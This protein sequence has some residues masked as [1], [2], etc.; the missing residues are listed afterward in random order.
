[1]SNY[2]PLA[3]SARLE[4]DP[5]L[6]TLFEILRGYG[7]VPAAKWLKGQQ[8]CSLTFAEMTRRSD[9]YAACLCSLAPESGWMALAVDTCVE[10]PGI[11]WGMI[12][13][14]HN[15][16]LLDAAA[17]DSV[18]Q[19]LLDEAGCRM[20][21]TKKPRALSGRA[22]SFLRSSAGLRMRVSGVRS[23]W[24]MLV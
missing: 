15:I 22:G 3:V 4:A 1:M 12:R 16:L 17:S 8:E 14:G 20:I 18:I 6:P 5:S 11:F 24:V 13:S 21:I 10:W 7:D 2:D 19:G 23:S 9:D